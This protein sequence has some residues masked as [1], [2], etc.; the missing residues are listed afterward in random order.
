VE[1]KFN[2]SEVKKMWVECF[3]RRNKSDNSFLTKKKPTFMLLKR[4]QKEGPDCV[5]ENCGVQKICCKECTYREINGFSNDY[6]S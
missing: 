6:F 1:I 5:A 2:D 4:E 3:E